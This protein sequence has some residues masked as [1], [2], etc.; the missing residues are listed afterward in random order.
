MQNFQQAKPADRDIKRLVVATLIAVNLFAGANTYA[1]V[2]GIRQNLAGTALAA[3]IDEKVLVALAPSLNNLDKLSG[4]ELITAL[5]SI[6]SSKVESYTTRQEAAYV[7]ARQLQ[8]SGGKDELNQA[9][10]LFADAA[11]LPPLFERCQWHISECAQTLGD[12][13]TVRDALTAIKL[14][15]S[16]S[17][18]KAN[19]EYGIAQSYLRGNE[20]ESAYAAFQDVREK[21]AKS[22]FA[23]GADYYLGEMLLSQ[24]EQQPAKQEQALSFFRSYLKESPSGHFAETIVNRLNA[25]KDFQ[26]SK[27]DLNLFGQTDFAAG[28]WKQALAD[29]AT[30][31]SDDLWFAKGVCLYRLGKHNEAIDALNDG[32]KAHPNDSRV[33]QA[34]RVLA[35]MQTKEKATKSWENILQI[36]D[37]Y[38]D[39]ALYNIG[40]RKE[41]DESAP[42]FKQLIT[43]Y[44]HSEYAPEASWWLFWDDVKHGGLQ[45][46]LSIAASAPPKF[47]NDFANNRL[48]SRFAFWSGKI[49][50]RLKQKDLALASYQQ[51][52]TVSPSNYYAH[53]ARSRMAYLQGKQDPGWTTL[54][55]RDSLATPWSLPEPPKLVSYEQIA[56]QCGITCALLARLNQWDEVT[57][58]IPSSVSP[59]IKAWLFAKAGLP[60]DA[61]NAAVE[62]VSGSPKSTALWMIAYPLIYQKEISAESS[63]RGVDPFLVHSL[64]RE[65]SRYNPMATSHSNALGLMQ[66]LPNTAFGIASKAGVSVHSNQDVYVPANN[67]KL[68][69]Y[70][71]SY[72]LNRFDG[73]A[74]AAVASYNGGPNAVASWLKKFKESGQ[75]DFDVFVE[76]IPLKE[77]RDYV[78]KVFGAYW[79]YED[80]YGKSG[81]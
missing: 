81:G 21:Y 74:L 30:N 28:N 29:W 78:R 45:S 40:V 77:P 13:K 5:K 60:L 73:N 46:A 59:T 65:E 39:V 36:T 69:T 3:N 17:Q 24:S 23:I 25:L 66:L 68:G 15:T 57:Q 61:I 35:E 19:A 67:I 62:Q 34:G 80:I 63:A 20:L 71:I 31:E 52:V 9:I 4:D 42:Y 72:V 16:D 37:K 50:E 55:S 64:V 18:T 8:K 27:S 11:K 79:N 6:Y 22:N 2:D 10:T 54:P 70:Y 12:E 14:H 1:R 47:A 26:P 76:D 43:D 7:L 49:H 51:A 38:K 75:T 53:R 48:R 32:I 58:L 33:P 41:K 44:P 56:S